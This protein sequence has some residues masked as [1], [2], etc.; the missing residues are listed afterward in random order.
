MGS[1]DA[2]K[3]GI[4]SA[5]WEA[6]VETI[7][8][9][10]RFGFRVLRKNPG[11]TT[12]AALTLALGIGASTAIFSVVN[13][14]LLRPLRV[15]D[16]RQLVVIA[17]KIS[18]SQL[19]HRVS[20]PDYLDLRTQKRIFS[21]VIAYEL[22]PVNLGGQP[23]PERIWVEGVT[24]DYFF[25][26]GVGAS[27]GRMFLP[28]ASESATGE[29][30]IVLSYAFWQRHFAGDPLV[31]GKIVHLNSP[32]FTVVGVAPESFPGTEPLV[33]VDA[34]VPLVALARL[35]PGSQGGLQQRD[36]RGLRAM[37]RLQSGVSLDQA[38]AE[39]KVFARHLELEYPRTNEA[40]SFTVIPEM[41]SR[42]DPADAAFVPQIVAVFMTL[43]GL[44][45]VIACA[46]FAGLLLA[47]ASG[48]GREMAIRA[49]LGAGRLRLARQQIT[50]GVLFGLL[51]G[52]AGLVL[53]AW[54]MH[55][56]AAIKLPTD[57]PVTLFTPSLDW[58]VFAF[59]LTISVITGVLASLVP[60]IRASRLDLNDSLKEGARA[61]GES[62]RPI[63]I[64]NLLVVSQIAV[65]VLLLLCSGLFIRSF[66]NA[67][68]M[69][70]GFRTD[71]LLMLSVDVGMQGYDKARGQRFYEELVEGVKGQP[72]T[73]SVSVAR[74][75]PFGSENAT[76]DIY[77]EERSPASKEPPLNAFYN[78][79]GLDYFRT[80]G[81]P[82]VRGRVFSEQ[83]NESSPKVA[84]ISEAMSRALWPGQD[85]L[86]KRIE[87]GRDGPW[88]EVIGVARNIK[89][90]LPYSES[91]S[92]VYL[93]LSQN[94]GSEITLVVHT[95]G[96]PEALLGAAREQVLA[97][98]RNLPCYDLKTMATHIRGGVALLPLRLAAT[99]VG[100]FG[101]AGLML[102]IVGLYGVV[103]YFVARRTHEIGIRVALGAQQRD[104]L[105]L[106]LGQGLRLMAIGLVLGL[107]AALA[108]T[109]FLASL[110]Y[111][112]S[113]TDALT[114]VVVPLILAATTLLAA[115]IP[116]RRAMKVDPM[117]ALRYE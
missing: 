1:L 87:L 48:R 67:E 101:L 5:G 71:H 11:F 84:I 55:L 108:L 74:F 29:P 54:V 18:P 82:L 30:V 81:T 39:A 66:K 103:S 93:P 23:Q 47:R 64:R 44:V 26:L 62:R 91:Q 43:V 58:R 9:D 35:P 12:V 83:D 16:P 99:L 10:L 7:W 80:M 69:D 88:A 113:A 76:S 72:W 73:R 68:Q 89:F 25:M 15:K 53:A 36:N 95:V 37:A 107:G 96:D 45:L 8:Q 32:P 56:L 24:P 106:V 111:G 31:T 40:V 59:A 94:Y 22:A 114:F 6:S 92:F 17:P 41:R 42:P 110:L 46:N 50:E 79:V 112:V 75:V 109:R 20:Y 116:A 85:P 100:S 27:R 65:S 78:I 77:T 3:E 34:Y 86:G 61:G 19:P 57:V 51:G 98:D 97:L 4:R 105:R 63:Q 52:G 33:A 115:F 117:V 2:V 28:E 21:D 60:S 13:S 14:L 38:I 70:L 102:A 90:T 104:V 49:A